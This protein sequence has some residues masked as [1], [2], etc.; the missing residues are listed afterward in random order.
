VA[1]RYAIR[2]E[3]LVQWRA[4][5]RAWKQCGAPGT[6]VAWLCLSFWS[7][8]VRDTGRPMKWGDVYARDL[9]RCS[10]PICFGRDPTPHHLL[11]RS[12]G[13]GDEMENLAGVCPWCHLEGVHGIGSIEVLPPASK[14]TWRFG[15]KPWLEVVGR[16]SR[17]L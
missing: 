9:Y 6:F 7:E 15:R 14:M 11:F 4:L 1:V 13:G 2:E 3:L 17:R 8:W 5:E 10:S 12:K 16:E